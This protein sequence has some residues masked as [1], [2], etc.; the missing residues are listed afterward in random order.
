ML[1]KIS[2]FAILFI[3]VM[4]CLLTGCTNK[5]T[6]Q[7][8]CET[9]KFEIEMES[10]NGK[11]NGYG[12]N[13]LTIDIPSNNKI[14]YAT[15]QD[16]E[17]MLTF[18]TGVIYF[19]FPECPWCRNLAPTLLKVANEYETTVLYFNNRDERDT[20]KLEN[21]EIVTDVEGSDGYYKILDMLG[22]Y[23]SVYEGLEDDSIK[24]LYYPTVVFVKNGNIIGVHTGTVDSQ[25]DVSVYLTDEQQLELT[26]ALSEYF[27]AVAP[28]RCNNNGKTC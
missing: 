10:L 23:A 24:R 14:K 7:P 12:G 25:D 1:K 6:E 3:L 26:N 28:E 17:N 16:V 13:Y 19:G 11:D 20:K 21:G 5:I 4:G 15:Y 27:E 18:G 2:S 8:T 9:N 22:D